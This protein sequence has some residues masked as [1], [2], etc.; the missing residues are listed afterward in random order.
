MDIKKVCAIHDNWR[1][2]TARS[3]PEKLPLTKHD[4][5]TWELGQM[6]KTSLFGGGSGNCTNCK[7]SSSEKKMPSDFI[8][9][10]TWT[11]YPAITICIKIKIFGRFIAEC[12]S[13]NV[14]YSLCIHFTINPW[15]EW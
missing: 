7:V 14:W 5:M 13:D 9:T 2:T 1:F 15:V 6:T 4:K 10:K 11:T 8:D 3:C 12:W